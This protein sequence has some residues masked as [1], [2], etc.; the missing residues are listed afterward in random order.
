MRKTINICSFFL[1]TAWQFNLRR[2]FIVLI[3]TALPGLFYLQIPNPNLMHPATGYNGT[4]LGHKTSDKLKLYQNTVL[5]YLFQTKMSNMVINHC[6]G[7]PG[8]YKSFSKN[9]PYL[10]YMDTQMIKCMKWKD[11]SCSS[12]QFYFPNVKQWL[13]LESSMLELGSIQM[14]LQTNQARDQKFHQSQK[15]DPHPWWYNP[16]RIL[17]RHKT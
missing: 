11:N 7:W 12:L 14:T 3:T 13:S 16:P 4:I 15:K 1:D 6:S 5:L 9:N 17:M 2:V 8:T 10:I